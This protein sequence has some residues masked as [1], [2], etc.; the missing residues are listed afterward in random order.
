M[1]KIRNVYNR[2]DEAENVNITNY[3]INC[4]EINNGISTS[5][6]LNK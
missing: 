2:C 4:N 1:E 6:P 3:L 5:F